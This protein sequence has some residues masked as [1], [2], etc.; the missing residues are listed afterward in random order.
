MLSLILVILGI[1]MCVPAFN[2]NGL[3]DSFDLKLYR[4]MLSIGV[5][6][7]VISIL[8]AIFS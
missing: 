1:A 2:V 7:I 6:C 4:V 5:F 8:T 3:T